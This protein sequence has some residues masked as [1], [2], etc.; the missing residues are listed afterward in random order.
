MSEFS[1][2]PRE[3]GPADLPAGETV[4]WRGKPDWRHLA[5]DAFGAPWVAF[6]FVGIGVWHLATTLHDGGTR[7]QA[8]A[9]FSV[10]L[11]PMALALSLVGTLAWL[12]ARSTVFTVTDRR[13]V[14]C[15]GVAL[16]AL[17]NLPLDT[18][19]AMRVRR[20]IAGRGDLAFSLPRKGRLAFHQ[21]WPY[22]RPWHLFPASPMMR[23]LPKAE[24]VKVIVAAALRAAAER[25]ALRL[26][27]TAEAPAPQPAPQP[28]PASLPGGYGPAHPAGATA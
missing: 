27:Q 6:Y 4:L 13:I 8:L 22:A 9:D 19:E 12:S 26:G 11:L 18:I 25:E 3:I 10:V 17:I 15:Y 7:A 5:L 23:A 24:E 14:M 16:P 20:G 21:L 2:I 28:A 1:D